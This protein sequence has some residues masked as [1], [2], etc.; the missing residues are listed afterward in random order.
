[1]TRRNWKRGCWIAAAAVMSFLMLVAA[2]GGCAYA[3]WQIVLRPP[4]LPAAMPSPVEEE[5]K[6]KWQDWYGSSD[7]GYTVELDTAIEV[8]GRRYYAIP[9]D[10]HNIAG[11]EQALAYTDHGLMGLEAV[12]FRNY[13]YRVRYDPEGDFLYESGFRD[14]TMFATREAV[15]RYAAPDKKLTGIHVGYEADVLITDPADMETLRRLETVQ[16]KTVRFQRESSAAYS[17]SLSCLYNDLPL[18]HRVATIAR[19]DG[20]FVYVKALGTAVRYDMPASSPPGKAVSGDY[21]EGIVIE[22]PDMVQALLHIRVDGEPVFTKE[23][24]QGTAL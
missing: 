2:M 13:L 9:K 1:M 14:G 19:V 3:G 11:T 22:D 12:A 23:G 17:Y 21:D 4:N 7:G 10:W 20:Q 24:R 16:G 6:I 18:L 5:E 8:D 15:E